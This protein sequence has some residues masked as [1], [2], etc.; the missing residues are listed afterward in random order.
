[1]IRPLIYLLLFLSIC[2][3]L[4]SRASQEKP[5]V[6]ILD[7]KISPE[8]QN[9]F[10]AFPKGKVKAL[11][12]ISTWCPSCRVLDPILK[13]LATDLHAVQFIEYDVDINKDILK[14]YKIESFPKILIL[15]KNNNFI[16]SIRINQR[17]NQDK[18]FQKLSGLKEVPLND[19]VYKGLKDYF[20]K[21]II[22]SDEF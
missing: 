15:D 12:F 13:K 7:T 20:I 10:K 3:N 9:D 22:P 19:D 11:V 17:I 5:I 6:E 8:A 14:N 4:A 21:K 18:E 2:F 16:E 1:M